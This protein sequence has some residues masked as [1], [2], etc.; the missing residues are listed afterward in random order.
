MPPDA[1]PAFPAVDDAAGERP[2]VCELAPAGPVR[3]HKV[4]VAELA[5]SGG[6]VPFQPAPEIAAAEPAEHCRPA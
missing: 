4:R 1:S 2:G 5:D 3:A 6:A